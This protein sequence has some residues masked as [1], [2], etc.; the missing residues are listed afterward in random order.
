[1]ITFMLAAGRG[2]SAEH[3]S[4]IIVGVDDSAEAEAAAKWAVREAELR[5]DDVL[6]VHAF[7]VPLLQSSSMEAAI[8]QGRQERQALLDKV[9]GTL[10]VPPRMHLDQRIEID[11]PESLLPRLSGTRS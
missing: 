1:M 6:L 3:S 7:E 10:A 4:L 8:A 9:A 5:R 2:E 11:S